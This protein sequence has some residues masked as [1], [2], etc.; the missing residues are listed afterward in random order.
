[1]APP[2][3]RFNVTDAPPQN[4]PPTLPAEVSATSP[5]FNVIV[6]AMRPTGHVELTGLTIT[7]SEPPEPQPKPGWGN[8]DCPEDP[9]R[10]TSSLPGP[11]YV[12]VTGF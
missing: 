7:T 6:G 4:I 3:E 2:L 11:G 9:R 8:V 5:G 10:P 1:M 12:P